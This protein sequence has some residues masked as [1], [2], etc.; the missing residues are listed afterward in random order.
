MGALVPQPMHLAELFDK[1]P[2][3]L[4]FS[5]FQVASNLCS[6]APDSELARPVGKLHLGPLS[7]EVS[8]QLSCAAQAGPLRRSGRGL[9]PKRP[10]LTSAAGLLPVTSDSSCETVLLPWLRGASCHCWQDSSIRK[11]HKVSRLPLCRDRQRMICS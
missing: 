11:S 2:C 5:D 6:Q 10:L 3:T 8:S 7:T 4:V 1:G 9:G